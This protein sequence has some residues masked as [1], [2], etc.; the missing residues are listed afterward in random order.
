MTDLRISWILDLQ[1]RKSQVDCELPIESRDLH[2]LR[3]DL[4]M[5]VVRSVMSAAARH[6]LNPT[7]IE[8]LDERSQTS[9][10]VHDL[11]FFTVRILRILY[12]LAE[13]DFDMFS[14]ATHSKSPYPLH[15]KNE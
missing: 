14:P 7:E 1:I 8:H 3:V 5:S 12:W 10:H 11:F 6:C 13:L 4:D 9:I 15:K 2:V